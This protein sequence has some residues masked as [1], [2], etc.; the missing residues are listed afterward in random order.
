MDQ[1]RLSVTLERLWVSCGLS[2]RSVLYPVHS[3][4]TS[5]VKNNSIDV[6]PAVTDS[7]SLIQCFP[8]QIAVAIFH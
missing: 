3:P 1:E 5:R 8:L 7:R 4:T 2:G 6:D